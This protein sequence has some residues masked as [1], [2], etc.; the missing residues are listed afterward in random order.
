[1]RLNEAVGIY[2]QAAPLFDEIDNHS[3]RAHFHDGFANVLNQL[4]AAE[5][6]EDYTDRALI[7]YAAASFHF[8]QA[9]HT[10][11]QACV[12]N[13]LGY[14]F[15]IIGRFYETHE[16]LDPAQALM[17]RPKENVHL[18]PTVDTR[19]PISASL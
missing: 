16:H 7:E 10:R 9:G 4:S 8:E 15:G 14:L 17:T 19:A 3:L 2:N 11:Y 18:T 6:R 12:E 13:N 5:N 1:M